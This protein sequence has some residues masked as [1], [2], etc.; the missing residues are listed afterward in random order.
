MYIYERGVQAGDDR[1][2]TEK[3]GEMASAEPGKTHLLA[4]NV[5]PQG[6]SGIGVLMAS[7]PCLSKKSRAVPSHDNVPVK[8]SAQGQSLRII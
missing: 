3:G 8:E 1:Q 2:A 4:F 5:Q 6:V 7:M